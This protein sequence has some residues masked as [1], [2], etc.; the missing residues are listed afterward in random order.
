MN[1]NSES[2]FR[3]SISIPNLNLNSES[4]SQFRI[5]ISIPNPNLN[6]ESQSQF[7]WIAS[8]LPT[9]SL[10]EGGTDSNRTRN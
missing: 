1:L 6:S 2:Q 8:L 4:Q 5:P 10:I 9:S 7:R 3:I